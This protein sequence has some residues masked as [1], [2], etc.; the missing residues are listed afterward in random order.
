[1]SFSLATFKIFLFLPVGVLH[2]AYVALFCVFGF[3]F[4]CMLGTFLCVLWAFYFCV[5]NDFVKVMKSAFLQIFFLPFISF[6]SFWDSNYVYTRLLMFSYRCWMLYFFF[7]IF[8]FCF[9]VCVCFSFGHFYWP[10]IKFNNLFVSLS[11]LMNL[12]KIFFISI[13]IFLHQLIFST[14]CRNLSFVHSYFSTLSTRIFKIIITS[15]FIFLYCGSN[16][17]AIFFIW[18]FYYISHTNVWWFWLNARI[19]DKLYLS[20]E[21]AIPLLLLIQDLAK[22]GQCLFSYRLPMKNIF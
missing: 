5:S 4:V 20:L 17:W 16:I 22:T 18:L 15:I 14:C 10:I 3:L 6:F 8:A 19:G 21:M 12:L 11:L 9:C 2:M 1:M 7:Q 13:V